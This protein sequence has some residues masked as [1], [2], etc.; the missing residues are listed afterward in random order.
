MPFYEVLI[1]ILGYSRKGFYA[2]LFQKHIIFHI[3]DIIA[4]PLL[5][6][7]L[8]QKWHAPYHKWE[9]YLLSCKH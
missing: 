4:A 5:A 2:W 6:W 1:Y 3:F 8:F 7:K 9:I